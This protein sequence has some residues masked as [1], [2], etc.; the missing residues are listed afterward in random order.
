MIRAA[1]VPDISA[2]EAKLVKLQAALSGDLPRERR[3]RRWSEF[4][5]ERDGHRCV[6]C[7]SR[8]RLSAHHI[9]RKSFLAEPQFETGNGITLCSACPR[10][11]HRGFNARPAL[12]YPADATG[13]E[14]LARTDGKAPRGEKGRQ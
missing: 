10:E 3:L 12:S 9:C 4:I 1:D 7:H 13:G 8:R 11:V 2:I 14:N 5:R 6:D